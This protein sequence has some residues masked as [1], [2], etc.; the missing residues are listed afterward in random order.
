MFYTNALLALDRYQNISQIFLTSINYNYGS[1]L[2]Q[3]DRNLLQ[4][5]LNPWTYDSRYP[6]IHHHKICKTI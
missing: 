6:F 2:K 5:S 1:G 3:N 4:G